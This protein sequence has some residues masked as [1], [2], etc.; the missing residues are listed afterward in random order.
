MKIRSVFLIFFVW[1]GITQELTAQTAFN[2]PLSQ[3]DFPAVLEEVLNTPQSS[4]NYNARLVQWVKEG[5]ILYGT[6]LNK[7]V[8]AIA[9]TLLAGHPQLA[10][11][12]HCFVSLSADVNAYAFQNGIIIVNMGL[13]AQVSNEAEL[14]FVLS[15]EIAHISE[16]HKHMVVKRSSRDNYIAKYLKYHQYSREHENEADSVGLMKFYIHTEY[17]CDILDGVYDVLKYASLPF[18]NIPYPRTEVETDFYH[19]PDNYFLT[20][21]SPVSDFSGVTDTLSTHPNLE[22]RRIV[23][24][25]L[26][27]SFSDAN[28]KR[29]IQSEELFKE[30]NKQA[31]LICVDIFL[32]EH[33][34]DK[35]LYN[36][37]VLKRQ[38]P[39]EAVL[40]K[41]EVASFYGG[42]KHRLNSS[43]ATAYQPYR[44]VEGEMQQVNY[45]F[46]KLTRNEWSALALRKAWQAHL[47]YPEDNYYQMVINDIM[48]D[49]FVTE[50]MQYTDF[51][52]Y[53]QT[54]AI[55][56]IQDYQKEDTLKAG[57]KYD[58]LNRASQAKVLPNP[59]FKTVNYMLVDIHSDSTF[60]TIMNS[61]V[62]DLV[63]EQ[64]LNAISRQGINDTKVLM[65]I[66]P[67]VNFY[68]LKNARKERASERYSDHLLKLMIRT[69]KH[70]DVSPVVVGALPGKQCNTQQYN[71]TASWQRWLTDY[72]NAGAVSMIYYT[73]AGMENIIDTSG[74]RYVCYTGVRRIPDNYK[75]WSKYL[76]T[77]STLAYPIML[78]FALVTYAFPSYSV[79]A[80]FMMA[81]IVTGKTKAVKFLHDEEVSARVVMDDFIYTQLRSCLT[82]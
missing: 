57:S 46:S 20:N 50:K 5:R 12:I 73:S 52:D 47:K 19:F 23:A 36:S 4:G 28:R 26:A 10:G 34:Y 31:K 61:V 75:S 49:I 77:V 9:E 71:E 72:I 11:Q 22:K 2:M 25:A 64:I 82:Q 56:D 70:Y 74:V 27:A 14:A 32:Q 35:A 67:R 41:A 13:I 33:Q 48:T 80:Q 51:C 79:V 55:E 21:V 1:I 76:Y 78:P 63:N 53:P 3:G 60:F 18:D 81:D 45:F 40:D 29:F 37:F 30:M 17:S 38:Y 66:S 6:P 54:V 69:A 65:I 59:K 7:Y 42:S 15:H 16:H 43:T 24:K 62:S 58:R 68:N 8:D 44:E 39:D